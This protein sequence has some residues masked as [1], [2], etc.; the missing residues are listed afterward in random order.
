MRARKATGPLTPEDLSALTAAVNDTKSEATGPII[1][2]P[3]R[4]A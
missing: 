2:V 1:Y 4:A 3:L